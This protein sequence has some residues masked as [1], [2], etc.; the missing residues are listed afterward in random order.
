MLALYWIC[1]GRTY[2]ATSSDVRTAYDLTLKAADILLG[3]ELALKLIRQIL[4][5]FPQ[6]LFVRESL[7]YAKELWISE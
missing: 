6:E 1:A 5:D 3:R 2:E 4:Q 7:A